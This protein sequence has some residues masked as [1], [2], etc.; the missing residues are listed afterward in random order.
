MYPAADG[1]G[2]L[3]EIRDQTVGFSTAVAA[4]NAA[5]ATDQRVGSFSQWQLQH[6]PDLV[7]ALLRAECAA[8]AAA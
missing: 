1:R 4:I 8:A 5:A 6:K 3:Q 7:Q 2:A